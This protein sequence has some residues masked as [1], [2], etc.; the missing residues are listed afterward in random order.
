MINYRRKVRSARGAPRL[1]FQRSQLVKGKL[2]QTQYAVA[3]SDNWGDLRDIP[4]F[5][6]SLKTQCDR[7]F[8]IELSNLD[9]SARLKEKWILS[10]GF[11]DTPID[12]K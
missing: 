7:A 8:Q 12:K 11:L 6:C 5:F 10:T 4:D 2:E 3:V 9:D 1:C